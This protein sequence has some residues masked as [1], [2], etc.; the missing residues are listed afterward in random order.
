MRH[1]NF[2][3]WILILLGVMLLLDQ[4]DILYFNRLTITLLILFA[5]G[6]LYLRKGLLHPKRKGILGGSFFLLAAISLLL[7]WAGL[8]PISDPVGFGLLFIDL[9]L[10]NIIF[11][12]VAN[13]RMINIV[14]GIVFILIGLPAFEAYPG[15]QL[16]HFYSTY[17]PVVLILI[18]LGILFEG[19]N[20]R[21]R[22]SIDS[23]KTA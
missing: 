7:M 12:F 19:F 5:L 13:K 23:S 2:A 1:S 4:L 15:W 14:M 10:A 16:E 17:W 9:G 6:V 20:Q 21:S 18:G 11:Y 3:A 22:K 8:F